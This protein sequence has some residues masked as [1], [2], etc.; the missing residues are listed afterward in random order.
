[1]DE[2][3]YNDSMFM[4][5]NT[6]GCMFEC[7]LNY[8]IMHSKCIPWDYPIPG[9]LNATKYGVCVAGPSHSEGRIK[10]FQELMDSDTS[11]KNCDCKPDCEHVKHEPQVNP[12]ENHI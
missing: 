11:M 12:N 1:M 3:S 7:R 2:A 10:F 4:Q 9:G 5:Y 6:L 8:S